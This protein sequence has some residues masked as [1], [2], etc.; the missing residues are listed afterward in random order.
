MQRNRYLPPF[1]VLTVSTIW[2]A[3]GTAPSLAQDRCTQLIALSHEYAH[4]P[5]NSEQ[6]RLKRRLVVWYEHNCRGGRTD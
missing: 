2:F 5:L 6:K 4:V 1:V 3:A